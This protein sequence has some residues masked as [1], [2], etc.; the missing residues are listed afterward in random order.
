MDSKKQLRS[1]NTSVKSTLKISTH[2]DTHI[3][4]KTSNRQRLMAFSLLS[5]LALPVCSLPVFVNELHYDNIKTDVNEAIELV[6][7]AGTDLSGWQ[8][9]LYNG[10]DGSVYKSRG[11]DGVFKNQQNGFGTLVFKQQMQNGSPDGVALVN[12]VGEVQ[13][14]LSYEGSFT[15]FDGAADG[16]TSLDL[17][18][19][20]SSST[21]LGYSLQLSGAGLDW[22][23]F[24]WA[25]DVSSYGWINDKQ[26]FPLLEQPSSEKVTVPEPASGSLLLAALLLLCSQKI[27]GR[28][29]S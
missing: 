2:Q 9:L 10:K 27:K 28:C 3:K 15:A 5:S 14:F 22:D 12:N 21:K 20:E 26:V 16:M 25:L 23:D 13:Q 29:I 24:T 1:V 19:A 11:L 8:L 18:I 17:G 6:G 7:L 4:R